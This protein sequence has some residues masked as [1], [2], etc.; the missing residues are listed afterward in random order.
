MNKWHLSK[1]FI[2][3]SAS[4]QRIRLLE[5][6]GFVPDKII[7]ADIDE[8]EQM[9]EAP[10]KYVQRM[11]L[12]KALCVAKQHKNC[13]VLGADTIVL[14]H[15]KIIRKAKDEAAARAN[16]SI[17][18]GTKQ[19]VIT[20]YAIVTPDGKIKTKVV[21]TRVETKKFSKDEIDCLIQANEWQNVAGYRIEGILSCLVKRI[22]GSYANIVGLPVYE[23]A[24]DLKKI[25]K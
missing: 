2:L 11:A 25:L 12:E 16:L 17:I 14:A 23:V 24:Q 10:K 3:A 7:P 20:G 4:P 9:G 15:G 6:A 19:S 18:S 22:E 8:S 5:C 21:E 1:G 13:C